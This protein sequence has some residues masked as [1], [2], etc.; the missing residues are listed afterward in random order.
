MLTR[1]DE[2]PWYYEMHEV[3]LNY[4]IP[5][6]NCAPRAITAEE[7]RSVRRPSS[8]TGAAYHA[9]FDGH[10]RIRPPR[11]TDVARSS[12]HIYAPHFD[13]AAA[14]TTRTDVVAALRARGVLTQVHY[15]PVPLQPYYRKLYGFS[16]GD[17]PGAEHHYA[18]TL[19]LP[20]YPSLTDAE[21]AHV[22]TCVNELL[23]DTAMRTV[24]IIQARM[25]STRLPGKVLEDIAGRPMLDHVIRRACAVARVDAV[26]VATT[27]LAHDE[28]LV[29]VAEDAGA[30][31]FRG[32][33]QDVLARYVGA[34]EATGAELIVRITSDCPLLDPELVDEMLMRREEL[35]LAAGSVDLYSNAVVRTFPRGLDTEIVPTDVLQQLAGSTDDPR[36]R[37]HVTW[38][39]YQDADRYRV[40]HH[41]ESGGRDR[42]D[43]RWT[44]D[45]PEDLEFVRRIYGELWEDG[46][47]FGR[48][49]VMEA[50]ER[51]PEWK[52]INAD[53]EQK[54][55]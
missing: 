36:A 34:A 38:G 8:G 32:S 24:A 45:T 42:S 23:G 22:V 46:A 25:G 53:V 21:Q 40:L 12:W 29:A 48:E 41:V 33:E 27:T 50:L 26:C 13:F 47:V 3:G 20:L 15:Y 54:R 18:G 35:S 11:P 7:A 44:V 43:H 4:R 49:A 51:H 55:V 10:P 9:A 5:D 31:T 19:T 17:F 28:P 14:G 1:P 37:E 52:R 16:D 30:A 39:L 6:V 2:G